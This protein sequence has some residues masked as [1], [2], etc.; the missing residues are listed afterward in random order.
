MTHVDIH[1]FP[2]F[3][4]VKMDDTNTD[5]CAK[6]PEPTCELNRTR[7]EMKRELRLRN[8]LKVTSRVALFTVDDY[9]NKWTPQL[10][11]YMYNITFIQIIIL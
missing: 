1:Y 6:D 11:K 4:I 8:V 3:L 7:Q 10:S 9:A 5:I 2:L